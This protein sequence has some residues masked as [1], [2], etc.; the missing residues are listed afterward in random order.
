MPIK[1]W[2]KALERVT[3]DNSPLILTAVGVAGTVSVAL[4]TAKASFKAADIILEEQRAIAEEHAF[5]WPML[6]KK[7]KAALVWKLYIPPVSVAAVT[8]VAI[9]AANRIGTRR[10]AALAAAYTIAEKGFEEYR[11]KIIE[12][13]GVNKEKA[14]RDEIAQE[15]VDKH[16]LGKTTIIEKGLV[17]CLDLYAN[18]WF[19]SDM[20]TI[21][22]AEIALNQKIQHGM[23]MT[24]SV[25][26]FYDLLDLPHIGWG[27]EVGWD[28]DNILE[29]SITAVITDDERPGLCMTFRTT[30]VRMQYGSH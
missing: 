2:L 26:E 25:N 29:L 4:L 5:D 14:A 21:Q 17:P 3:V 20:Q 13:V 19:Q 8:V 27:E 23:S 30:P 10:A 7:E 1:T 16:P 18:R 6:S 11:E 28:A 9:I 24:A 15:R 22:R 12:K